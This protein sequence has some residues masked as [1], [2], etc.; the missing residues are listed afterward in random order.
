MSLPTERTP[1]SLPC[2][3]VTALFAHRIQTRLPS[4]VRFSF[5]LSVN[6]SGSCWISCIS[7]AR[8]RPDDSSR[9]TIVPMTF[10]PTS[11]SL[12]K[13]KKRSPKSLM[14]R[15]VPA[16]SQVRMTE[17]AA[18]TSWR[19]RSSLSRSASSARFRTTMSMTREAISC[20]ISTSSCS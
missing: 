18:W 3:S 12:P 16:V 1:T 5:S 20:R 2:G 4:F 10:L 17:L 9:G 11:S 7:C 14:N 13:P 8:S 6:R 15:M 19:Y